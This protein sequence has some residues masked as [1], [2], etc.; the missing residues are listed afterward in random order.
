[1]KHLYLFTTSYCHL[2]ETAYQLVAQIMDTDNL[3]V[4]EISDDAFLL[5]RYGLKIPVL[6]RKDTQ[7]ELNWPF[8]TA[9]II[10][11]LN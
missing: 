8:T 3:E 10:Q 4:V 11:F 1:M 2:C 6:Q 9:D 5:A 7:A